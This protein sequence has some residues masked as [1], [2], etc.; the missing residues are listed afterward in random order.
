MLLVDSYGVDDAH[1]DFPCVTQR[2]SSTLGFC[3]GSG[4]AGSI[5]FSFVELA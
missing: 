4:L 3:Q 2:N 5:G 1:R